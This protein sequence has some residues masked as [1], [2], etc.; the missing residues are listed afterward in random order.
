M[1]DHP[2]LVVLYHPEVFDGYYRFPISILALAA[3]LE[4]GPY[5]VV[6]VDEN[7]ERDARAR[8]EELAPSALCVGMTTMPGRQT[9]NAFR[10]SRRLKSMHPRLPI[11]WGGYFASM[12]PEACLRTGVVD[13]GYKN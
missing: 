6:I 11:V 4:S 13:A 8:L 2:E 12:H 5:R 10:A 1:R 7:V 9:E 3:P